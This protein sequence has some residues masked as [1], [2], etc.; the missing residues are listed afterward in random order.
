MI[1]RPFLRAVQ[2]RG[3]ASHG[4]F[5]TSSPHGASTAF[6][7]TPLLSA[8]IDRHL[9]TSVRR[10]KGRY[11]TCPSHSP[12]TLQSASTI[13][14]SIACPS[15]MRRLTSNTPGIASPARTRS[16]ACLVIVVTSWEQHAS[17]FRGPSED[18]AIVSS[19]QASVLE[20]HEIEV[21]PAAKQAP[22]DPVVEVLVRGETQHE[23]LAPIAAWR[24]G[25]RECRPDRSAARSRPA[26]R[27]H[28]VC[29]VAGNCGRGP[30]VA[31]SRR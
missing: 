2:A 7:V 16:Y 3:D 8:R 20:S 18:R 13:K 28:S 17:L 14:S 30:G 1:L 26:P 5:P 25:D 29:E 19:G 4:S 27:Q 22:N 9:R 12:G 24:S 10:Y 31:S 6:R 23:G 21:G 11:R 15:G